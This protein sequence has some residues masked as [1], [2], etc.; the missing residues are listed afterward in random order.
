MDDMSLD[1]T[2]ENNALVQK[3]RNDRSGM[4]QEEYEEAMDDFLTN[5]FN[6]LESLPG[7]IH[8]CRKK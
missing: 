8:P 7:D 1:F 3:R 2:D 6:E 5:L 4:S